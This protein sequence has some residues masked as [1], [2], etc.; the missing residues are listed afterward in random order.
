MF[1][2]VQNSSIGDLVTHW[3]TDSI[4]DSLTVLLLLTYKERPKRL[5]NFETLYQSDEET[6][7]DQ[8]FVISWLCEFWL[9]TKTQWQGYCKKYPKS[10]FVW[11]IIFISSGSWKIFQAVITKAVFTN[12]VS[13]T[14]RVNQQFAKTFFSSRWCS[15]F[16]LFVKSTHSL[17]WKLTGSS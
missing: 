3:L 1:L 12:S 2:A 6:W 11:I 7:P 16:Y 8:Q 13:K 5:V 15:V 4:T 9:T 10:L 17:W 14:F